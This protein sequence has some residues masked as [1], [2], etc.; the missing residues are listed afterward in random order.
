MSRLEQINNELKNLKERFF[1]SSGNTGSYQQSNGIISK[2]SFVLLVLIVF[3]IL[4]QI[5]VN[6]LYF[7]YAC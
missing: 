6:I 2:F 4:F 7:V 3:I 5:I 1:P